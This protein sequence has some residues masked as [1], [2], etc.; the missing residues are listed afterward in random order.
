MDRRILKRNHKNMNFYNLKQMFNLKIGNQIDSLGLKKNPLENKFLRDFLCIKSH[1]GYSHFNVFTYQKLDS[2]GLS[3]FYSKFG[4]RMDYQIIKLIGSKKTNA[5]FDDCPKLFSLFMVRWQWHELV[6][7]LPCPN[8]GKQ[9]KSK[10]Q[11]LV[12]DPIGS[13][14]LLGRCFVPRDNIH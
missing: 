7:Q 8:V 9:S 4:F 6:S 14:L 10:R 11:Q 13:I 2:D 3:L 5:I 12:L 1:K